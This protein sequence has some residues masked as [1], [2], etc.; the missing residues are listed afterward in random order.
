MCRKILDE[1]DSQKKKKEIY[2]YL[3]K[4]TAMAQNII[5]NQ[6]ELV[7]ITYLVC[8]YMSNLYGLRMIQVAP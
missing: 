5:V 1:K 3:C 2:Q 4:Y 7:N 8:S 6:N